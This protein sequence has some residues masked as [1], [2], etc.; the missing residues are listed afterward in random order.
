MSP[1]LLPDP[2]QLRLLCLIATD[3]RITVDV[4]PKAVTANCPLCGQPSERVH[5]RYRRSLA[6][7]PRSGLAVCLRLH[8]RRFFCGNHACNRRIF[9]ERLPGVVDPYARRTTRLT[10]WFSQVAFALGGEPGA[11][12]G[13]GH[14]GQADQ[15][16]YVWP[17]QLRSP[18]SARRVQ[19]GRCITCGVPDPFGQPI[20]PS[21][22]ERRTATC[23]MGR[24]M[25]R[26]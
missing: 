5:S 14:E 12:G 11:D 3:E 22:G 10:S 23:R 26:D 18:P 8:A 19:F 6:D 2:T 13:A 7:L 20:P 16:Q 21:S 25:W 1:T 24:G 15:A 17:G 4:C 9:T